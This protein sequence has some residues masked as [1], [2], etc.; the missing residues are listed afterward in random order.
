MEKLQVGGKLTECWWANECLL[1]IA[2]RSKQEGEEKEDSEKCKKYE[3]RENYDFLLWLF[4]KQQV[5]NAIDKTVV[6]KSSCIWKIVFFPSLPLTTPS[7]WSHYQFSIHPTPRV[8][9]CTQVS[10]LFLFSFSTSIGKY[11]NINKGER[12]WWQWK[13]GKKL[14]PSIFRRSRHSIGIVQYLSCS[15]SVIRRYFAL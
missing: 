3:C 7:P 12:R 6:A 8:V 2:H 13:K 10:I 14:V 5:A 11:A 9:R 4:C 1:S 15:S